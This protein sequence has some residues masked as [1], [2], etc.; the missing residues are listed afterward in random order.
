MIITVGTSFPCNV[1]QVFEGK[2]NEFSLFRLK[3]ER[4][5]SRIPTPITS[6]TIAPTNLIASSFL[7][8]LRHDFANAAIA[9]SQILA[10]VGERRD[11]LIK[12]QRVPQE[13]ADDERESDE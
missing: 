5:H 2:L 1:T 13:G 6:S 11:S 9:A 8:S 3:L 12:G 7:Q 4:R 10:P